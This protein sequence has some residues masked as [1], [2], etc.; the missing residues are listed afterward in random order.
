M[1]TEDSKLLVFDSGELILEISYVLPPSTTAIEIIPQIT[2]VATYSNGL[3]AGIST[4][5]AVFFEKT[6]DAYLYKKSKEYLLED[7]EVNT[8]TI[9]PTETMALASL[10]NGQ[11]YSLPIELDA[12]RV[13]NSICSK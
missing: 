7:A 9:N 4:G 10:K 6:D 13:I 12:S 11:I 5:V 8:I 1:G 2:S 3:V